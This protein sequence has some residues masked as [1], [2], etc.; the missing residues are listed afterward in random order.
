MSNKQFIPPIIEQWIEKLSDNTVNKYSKDNYSVFLERTRD[1]INLALMKY[2]NSK[3]NSK[4][5]RK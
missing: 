5:S 2:N 4:V 1:A 3:N